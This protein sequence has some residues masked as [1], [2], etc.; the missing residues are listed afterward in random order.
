[1]ANIYLVES[2]GSK[3]AV[4]FISHIGR[5][6]GLSDYEVKSLRIRLKRDGFWARKDGTII[7][8]KLEIKKG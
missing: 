2:G 5:I 6:W 7:V 8:W 4:K 3:Y 1:M